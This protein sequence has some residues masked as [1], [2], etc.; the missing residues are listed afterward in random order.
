MPEEN[1]RLNHQQGMQTVL[2]LWFTPL[3]PTDEF[4]SHRIS[5][6]TE[7]TRQAEK[8]LVGLRIHLSF[9]VTRTPPLAGHLPIHGYGSNLRCREK[10]HFDT[11]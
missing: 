9:E 8:K 1:P 10:S 6:Y 3:F 4:C 11:R 2:R 5:K 7:L